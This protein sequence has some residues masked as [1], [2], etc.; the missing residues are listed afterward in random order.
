MTLPA[1]SKAK[2]TYRRVGNEN[3][4]HTLLFIHGAGG[5]SD[6]LLEL[7]LHFKEY[8]C[9]LVDL[10]GHGESTEEI[11]NSVTGYVD[12]LENFITSE[13]QL[14][15][16]DVTCIGHSMGGMITLNLA[17]RKVPVI[18]QIVILNSSARFSLDQKF[19]DK[20]HNGIL[21]KLYLFK[22]SGS[23]FHPRTYKFFFSSLKTLSDQVMIKD[24][25]LIENF[26]L[27]A[28]ITDI[29]IPALIVTGEK[30]ILAT[31]EDA[32]FLHANIKGSELEIMPKLAH[33]LP[34]IA[35]EKL[36]DRIRKFLPQNKL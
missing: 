14:F 31:K 16:E 11:P 4:Q 8:N 32:E 21:D 27:K 22:A 3:N 34:I 1:D 20:I 9:I 15:G 7:A 13:K 6:S 2:I 24:F 18:R 36:A 26:D 35:H 25:S 33:L 12:A 28:Q 10:L 29:A 17:I 19:M 30:E 5:I 23:Y